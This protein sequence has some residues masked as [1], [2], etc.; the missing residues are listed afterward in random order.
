[1]A[2]A[3]RSAAGSRPASAGGAAARSASPSPGPRPAGRLPAVPDPRGI[4]AATEPR[5]AASVQS[6]RQGTA[7]HATTAPRRP[8]PAAVAAG[9]D[10]AIQPALRRPP[11]A[12]R[13]LGLPVAQRLWRALFRRP[14]AVGGEQG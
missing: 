4:V 6:G 14:L 1:P 3:A 2:P 5:P 7:R 10:G 11:G 9:R 8:R 12:A 13:R